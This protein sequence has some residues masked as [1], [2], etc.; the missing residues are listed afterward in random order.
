MLPLFH[1]KWARQMIVPF[2]IYTILP[3]L[4]SSLFEINISLQYSLFS[5]ILR[6]VYPILSLFHLLVHTSAYNLVS[7]FHSLGH[8]SASRLRGLLT[9]Q[10]ARWDSQSLVCWFQQLCTFPSSLCVPSSAPY[11]YLSSWICTPLSGPQACLPS[12]RPASISN[13]KRPAASRD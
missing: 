10:T 8:S 9:P 4:S 13:S 5:F 3:G 7:V 6:E 12:W 2:T 1:E 11:L